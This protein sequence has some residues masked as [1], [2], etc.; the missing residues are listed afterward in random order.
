M[1]YLQNNQNPILNQYMKNMEGSKEM[2]FE[3]RDREPFDIEAWNNRITNE[4]I[5]FALK[6]TKIKTTNEK[7]RAKPI[8]GKAN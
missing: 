8:A 1:I 4:Q 2:F 7:R 5:A 6:L 3:M